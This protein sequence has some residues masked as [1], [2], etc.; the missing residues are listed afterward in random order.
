MHHLSQLF[1]E[2]LMKDTIEVLVTVQLCPENMQRLN[3]ALAPAVIHHCKPDDLEA[4]RACVHKIDAAILEADA[5]ECLLEGRKLRWIHCC[6]AGLDKTARPEVFERGIVLT[7]SAGRSAPA[8]AEH[9]VMFM[10]ALTYDLSARMHEQHMRQWHPERLFA[11]NAMCGKT[12]GIVGMG[13]TGLAL[14]RR[15]RAFDM[16]ILGWRR[17]TEVPAGVEKVYSSEQNDSFEDFLKQCDF[18]VLC[19]GLNDRTWHMIDADALAHMPKGSYLINVSRGGL[20]NENALIDALRSGH[21]AGA[22]LDNFEVEPLSEASP[23]WTLPNVLITPHATPCVADR[24]DQQLS[25]VLHNIE[26]FRGS[27]DFVNLL[28]QRDVYTHIEE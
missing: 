26:A 20:V 11:R 5:P 2:I 23:L 12:V 22:G 8:L 10:L 28:T 16:R 27:K 18:V 25:Y 17:S 21:L 1:G 15:L 14:V 24:E 6:H 19:A 13:N 4:I 7:S 3:A 9:A